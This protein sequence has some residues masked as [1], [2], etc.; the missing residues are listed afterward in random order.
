ML[1]IDRHHAV[2]GPGDPINT[3]CL[4]LAGIVRFHL[5]N[6][7]LGDLPV[8]LSADRIPQQ[9]LE[10]AVALLGHFAGNG[11]RQRPNSKAGKIGSGCFV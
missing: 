9:T 6:P 3:K 5:D 8:M 7:F 2:H 1:G 4:R 11:I 10:Q